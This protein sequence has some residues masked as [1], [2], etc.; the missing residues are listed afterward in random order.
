M[1]FA[2]DTVL[3]TLQRRV[4]HWRTLH[5]PARSVIFPQV[6][7]PGREAAFDFTDAS[8]LAV[9]LGGQALAHLLFVMVLPFSGWLWACVAASES[10]EAVLR[11]IQ[12]ALWG[13]GGVPEVLRSDNLSA[14]THEMPH[15]KGCTVTRLYRAL[16][17]GRDERRTV[18]EAQ[19]RLIRAA[20][21]P[22]V[23]A[24]WI[25]SFHTDMV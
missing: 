15:S 3:R 18:V 1:R 19:Q 11:G 6:H 4:E 25:I 14:A 24:R 10:F 20:E 22:N 12:D 21:P 2:G 8:D 7:P 17:V 23:A 5:G 13:L 16:L 9:T